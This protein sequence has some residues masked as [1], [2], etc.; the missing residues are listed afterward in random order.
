MNKLN[1]SEDLDFLKAIE[2]NVYQRRKELHWG[3]G[4]DYIGFG[5]Y[6]KQIKNFVSEFS[7]IKIVLYDDF[8]YDTNKVMKDIYKYLLLDD[9]QV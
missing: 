6:F 4:Y 7:N 2:S 1:N 3:I 9:L 5:E 8:I